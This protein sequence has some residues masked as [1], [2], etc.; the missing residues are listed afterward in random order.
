MPTGDNLRAEACVRRIALVLPGLDRI[1]GAE[2]QVM[3]LAQG[4]N[5]RGWRVSVVALSGNGGDAAAELSSAG[6]QFLSL[7]MRKGLADPARLGWLSSMAAAGKTRGDPR[8]S[9][10]CGVAGPLDNT[11]RTGGVLM[12]ASLVCGRDSPYGRDLAALF[13]CS[14]IRYTVLDGSL[15]RRLGYRLSRMLPD[16]VT[17]VSEAAAEAHRLAGMVVP[18]RDSV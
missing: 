11:R 9:A 2:R 3:L 16:Q 8:P 7:G 15:G 10:A 6:I 12:Q 4:L 17:A 1:G 13:R 14:S 5:R 18:R